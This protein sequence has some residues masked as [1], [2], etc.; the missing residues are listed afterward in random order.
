VVLSLTG[1][2][3]SE[4][5]KTLASSEPANIDGVKTV[6]NNLNVVDNTFHPPPPTPAQNGPIPKTLPSG[7]V[8]TICLNTEIDTKTAKANDSF[9]G[10]ARLP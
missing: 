3:R 4:A 8:I 9:A 1:N 6:L 5:E 2:V 10:T 7:S